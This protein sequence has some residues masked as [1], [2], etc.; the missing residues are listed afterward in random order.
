MRTRPFDALEPLGGYNVH[1]AW[2]KSQQVVRWREKH[3]RGREI[4]AVGTGDGGPRNNDYFARYHTIVWSP[5]DSVTGI[6]ASVKACRCVAVD[7]WPGLSSGLIWDYNASM[8][9]RLPQPKV[10]GPAR[11]EKLAQFLL[12]EVYPHHDDLCLEEAYLISSYMGGY[13]D[14]GIKKARRLSRRVRAYMDA[15]RGMAG[16]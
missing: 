2:L 6:V 16:I 9:E 4:P 15:C 8:P 5:S 14:Y 13:N 10:Y 12:R 1:E 3:L 11:L 7:V